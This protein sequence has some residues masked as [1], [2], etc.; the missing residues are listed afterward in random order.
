[1]AN[2]FL[3]ENDFIMYES[4]KYLLA[5][6]GYTVYAYMDIQTALKDLGKYSIDILLVDLYINDYSIIKNFIFE[7][8]KLFSELNIIFMCTY[9]DNHL[10]HN[11]NQHIKKSCYFLI[12]PFDLNELFVLID[13]LLGK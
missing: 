8:I 1:M 5:K 6:R 13:K 9:L 2:I 4:L 11:I 12:K 7:V 3:I 10:L